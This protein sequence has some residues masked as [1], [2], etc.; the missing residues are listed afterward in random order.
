MSELENELSVAEATKLVRWIGKR[1]L[2]AEKARNRADFDRWLDEFNEPPVDQTPPHLLTEHSPLKLLR[3]SNR[4]FNALTAHGIYDISELLLH[5]RQDL[6]DIRNL[7]TKSANEVLDRLDAVNLSLAE[8]NLHG[9]RPEGPR[10][11]YR[12]MAP[13]QIEGS[14]HFDQ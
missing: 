4:A 9:S 1:G 7:G 8:E 13:C 10:V 5:S 11:G 3:L 12:G 2:S 6:A 14:L